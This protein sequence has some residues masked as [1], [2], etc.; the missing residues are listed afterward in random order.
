MHAINFACYLLICCS[1]KNKKE[2]LLVLE[3]IMQSEIRQAEKDKY[4]MISVIC[5]IWKTK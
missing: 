2:V 3:G 5:G 4:S 1:V